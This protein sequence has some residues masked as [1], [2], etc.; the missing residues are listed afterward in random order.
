MPEGIVLVAPVGDGMALPSAV[1][2][3]P[4]SVP[5][6]LRQPGRRGARTK[7]KSVALRGT[8]AR[9]LTP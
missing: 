7:R 1:V 2:G 6:G 9:P 5:A 4:H 8:T 3:E